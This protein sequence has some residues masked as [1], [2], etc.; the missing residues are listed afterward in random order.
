MED[1]HAAVIDTKI[2]TRLP[3]RYLGSYTTIFVHE[4]A[5]QFRGQRVQFRNLFVFPD[6]PLQSLGL[7]RFCFQIHLH[8]RDGDLQRFLLPLITF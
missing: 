2:C 4:L 1:A 7:I 6:E 3:S 8:L 5:D